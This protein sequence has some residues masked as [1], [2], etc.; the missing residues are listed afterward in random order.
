MTIASHVL[1]PILRKGN[2]IY[3]SD[4]DAVFEYGVQIMAGPLAEFRIDPETYDPAAAGGDINQISHVLAMAIPAISAR[5]NFYR[6]IRRAANKLVISC[7]PQIIHLA[8]QLDAR[9]TI[10]EGEIDTVIAE[11]QMATNMPH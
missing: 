1:L 8:G 10:H 2:I 3:K 6:V 9:L 11:G 4:K 7:W 5:K